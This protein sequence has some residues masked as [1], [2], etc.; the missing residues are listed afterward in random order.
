MYA[1]RVTHKGADTDIKPQCTQVKAYMC[2][3]THTQVY[4]HT[5]MLK[6]FIY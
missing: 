2:T 5:V 4:T 3:I 1:C 6:S